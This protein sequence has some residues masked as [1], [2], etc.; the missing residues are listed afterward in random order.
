MLRLVF[1]RHGH[2]PWL[3]SESLS[4]QGKAQALATARELKA[5][6]IR[7]QRIVSTPVVRGKETADIVA[8]VFS[9]EPVEGPIIDTKLNENAEAKFLRSLRE[10]PDSI[11]TIFAISHN[12]TI[13]EMLVALLTREAGM[14]MMLNN[15]HEIPHGGAVI[16]DL[17]VDRWSE[18]KQ[19]TASNYKLVPIAA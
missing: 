7:P 3:D 4:A 9:D 1:M 13:G 8:G 5:K 6:D 11:R 16:V 2:Y 15:L 17:D 10:T 18:I 14:E 19:N 12:G